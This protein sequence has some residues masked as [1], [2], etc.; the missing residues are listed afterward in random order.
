MTQNIA[1]LIP[2]M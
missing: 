1:A 2:E